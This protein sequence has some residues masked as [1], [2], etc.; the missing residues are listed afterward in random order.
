MNYTH[1]PFC[2]AELVQ[3]SCGNYLDCLTPEDTGSVHGNFHFFIMQLIKLHLLLLQS[4]I[5]L[6]NMIV[7]LLR[8]VINLILLF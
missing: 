6:F 7:I 4:M 8:F 2:K 5:L 3:S 1:C